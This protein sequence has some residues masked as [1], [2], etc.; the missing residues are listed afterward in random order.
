VNSF[1]IIL[2]NYK[3]LLIY[4]LIIFIFNITFLFFPLVNVF[5]FEFSLANS[6]LL[7]FVSGIYTINYF[8]KRTNLIEPNRPGIK[9]TAIAFLI[10]LIVP[11]VISLVYSFFTMFCSVKDGFLFYLV[12]TFPSVILGSATGL[13]TFTYFRKFRIIIFIVITVLIL[14][15]PLF[16]FYYNPQ[17]F[18]FNPVF[19]FFPGTIYDEG[20]K[21]STKLI[22]YRTLNLIFFGSIIL[23]IL[24]NINKKFSKLFIGIYVIVV[25]SLFVYLSPIFGFSVTNNS[26]QKKLEN[27]FQTTHFNIYF[28]VSIP[29]N[30]A[31]KITLEH[32]YDYEQLSEFFKLHPDDKITSYVFDSYEQKGKYFGSENADIAK[33]WLKQIYI[34]ADSYDQTL[35]HELAHVFAA[36]FGT[37]IFKVAA[38]LNPALIEG[39]AVAAAPFYDEN[40]IHYMAALAYKNNYKIKIE[41]LFTGLNFFGSVSSLSYIYAGSFSKFLIERYG[42]MKFEKLYSDLNFNEVYNEPVENLTKTYYNFLDSLHVDKNI[43]KANYYFGRQ[44]IF[45]KVCPRYIGE[46]LKTARDYYFKKDFESAKNIFKEILQKTN[47]Y[48]ALIG[49]S[50]IL[51]KMDDTPEAAEIIK[52]N[53]S[54][55]VNTA[56]Y[57]NL[58]LRLADLEVLNSNLIFADSLY[59]KLVT[60]KPN[61]F[62]LN[63]SNMR[64]QLSKHSLLQE[65]VNGT[66]SQR[67]QILKKLNSIE[68]SYSRFPV[69]IELSQGLGVNYREFLTEF[70]TNFKVENYT[71]SY[72]M[73]KLSGFM[74]DNLDFNNARKI[75]ELSMNF[76]ADENFNEIL[77]A[78]F[79]KANW[80]YYNADKILDNI[81]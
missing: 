4:L 9:K 69:L 3:N 63:I 15:M 28:S 72:A 75:A 56:Y 39:A 55:F 66:N 48:S 60:E 44:T 20:I 52:S 14:T 81:K 77:R 26:L 32:E 23:L 45:R 36:G 21:V 10:F 47:N 46:R 33:P 25:S 53:I 5:G 18:F 1:T 74:M 34:S 24:K 68:F 78:N 49:L 61:R 71:D 19:G 37:G 35:R 76:K 57:Y 6:V 31:K 67:L 42:I 50:S 58:E 40:S 27:N 73:Y 38:G 2:E 22:L 12:I 8:T 16:E 30:I 41:H 43:N 54:K 70:N 7:F 29:N 80:F 79:E 65:Y 62:L 17:I 11:L 59:K 13:L 51:V 64:L